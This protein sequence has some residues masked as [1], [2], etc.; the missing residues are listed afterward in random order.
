MAEVLEPADP[1]FVDDVLRGH[2]GATSATETGRNA[3]PAS[4]GERQAEQVRLS[5]GLGASRDPSEL[6]IR[7][8]LQGA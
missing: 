2:S 8:P 4:V 3:T 5:R 7:C 6:K 1:A